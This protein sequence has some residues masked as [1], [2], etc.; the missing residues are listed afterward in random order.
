MPSC[1]GNRLLRLEFRG[2]ELQNTGDCFRM[3]YALIKPVHPLL[4]S[5]AGAA[6]S[7]DKGGTNGS[8]RGR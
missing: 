4:R 5:E 6:I 2:S 8:D 1:P 3:L 7:A